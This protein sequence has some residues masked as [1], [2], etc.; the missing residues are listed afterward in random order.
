MKRKRGSIT[1]ALVPEIIP[2]KRPL[3]ESSSHLN[4]INLLRQSVAM[5]Q[6][7]NVPLET[8]DWQRNKRHRNRLYAKSGLL[9]S[10]YLAWENEIVEL[11]S[12]MLAF[13]SFKHVN[14][15]PMAIVNTTTKLKLPKSGCNRCRCKVI[16]P[17]HP[18]KKG[19]ELAYYAC[20]CKQK[21]TPHCL[22]CVVRE[23]LNLARETQGALL[24]ENNMPVWVPCLDC[25]CGWTVTSIVLIR[26][27]HGGTALGG[28]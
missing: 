24:N 27:P 11:L 10:D 4:I 5:T 12:S 28:R 13:V 8:R 20:K 19:A 21:Q 23:Y 15:A 22:R 14:R 3:V 16:L 6:W 25:R 18:N 17:N 9:K 2:C 7:R 26:E 1:P